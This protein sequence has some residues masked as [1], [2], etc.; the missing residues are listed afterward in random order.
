MPAL[1][2]SPSLCMSPSY[3]P[4]VSHLSFMAFSICSS[5]CPAV[6]PFLCPS[7]YPVMSLYVSSVLCPLIRACSYMNSLK[8]SFVCLSVSP[9]VY[10]SECPPAYTLLCPLLYL[11]PYG[12]PHLY[13]SSPE[14]LASNRFISL[15][16]PLCVSLSVCVSLS[17]SHTSVRAG[18]AAEGFTQ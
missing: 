11:P 5:L 12:I 13:V 16:M 17:A 15:H 1:F 2:I 18:A 14:S 10:P 6:C 7:V 3:I 8:F 9:C 4:S